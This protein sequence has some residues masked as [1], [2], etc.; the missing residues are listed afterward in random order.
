MFLLW[1][2]KIILA[3]TDKFYPNLNSKRYLQQSVKLYID[4]AAICV[5]NVNRPKC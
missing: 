2:I 1:H 3:M 4:G 5:V